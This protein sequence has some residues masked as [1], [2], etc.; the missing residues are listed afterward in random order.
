MSEKNITLAPEPPNEASPQLGLAEHSIEEL[1]S[2]L[3]AESHEIV[4][5]VL[6]RDTADA[7]EGMARAFISNARS[8]IR[9]L[10]QEQGA[11]GTPEQMQAITRTGACHD[12]DFWLIAA[13]CFVLVDALFWFIAGAQAFSF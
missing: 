1:A 10:L 5:S 11:V 2:L 12:A 9:Q 7:R 6:Y 4:R 3:D 8:E 13:W